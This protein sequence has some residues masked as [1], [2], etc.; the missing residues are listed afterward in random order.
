MDS[1][2]DNDSNTSDGG[3]DSVDGPPTGDIGIMTVPS[4][5]ETAYLIR[6]KLLIC[7]CKHMAQDHREF[8]CPLPSL[9]RVKERCECTRSRSS[10]L[11]SPERLGDF[12][13]PACGQDLR[14]G[15]DAYAALAELTRE[16]DELRDENEQ[17]LD[18]NID[19]VI[20]L[21]GGTRDKARAF[22]RRALE[23]SRTEGT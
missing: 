16:R 15:P 11:K 20:G 23:S 17:L 12:D 9:I 18:W 6:Q 3:P 4:A 1:N 13:C 10:L 19:V 7:E 21:R 14:L 22:I 5:S 8:G 2:L